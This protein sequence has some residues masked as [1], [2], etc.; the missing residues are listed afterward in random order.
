MTAEALKT[1]LFFD[2]DKVETIAEEEAIIT[3]DYTPPVILPEEAELE[4]EPYQP[5]LVT[6]QPSTIV[7]QPPPSST[8]SPWPLLVGGL[9]LLLVLMLLVDTYHFILQQFNSSFFL[10]TL[11]LGLIV[12]ISGAALTLSWRAYKKLQALRTVSALQKE[13]RQ[14]IEKEGYGGAIQYINRIAHFYAHRPDIKARQERFYLTLNDTHH[15]REVCSLFSTQV[16]KDID[17]Q[18]YHIVTQR[19]K[20]TALMVMISQIA[21]LDAVLTLWRNVRMIRDV[22]TLYGGRPGFLGSIGLI[23][24]VLQNLIYADVSEMVAESVAEMM[25]GS[26]LSVMSAQIAQGLGS[27]VLTARLGLYAMQACRPLPFSEE[28]KPRLKHIRWEIMSSLTGV[29]EKKEAQTKTN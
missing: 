3:L 17:Q 20:E 28:E 18:A 7:S 11:F 2:L 13:G 15:D 16:M 22:A 23:T 12:A 25:G 29:F 24:G 21:L 14:L 19:S 9:G 4:L 6:P 10:G 26:V 1:P 8:F 27:G 5:E